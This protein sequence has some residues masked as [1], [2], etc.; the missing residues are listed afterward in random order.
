MI[1]AFGVLLPAGAIVSRY[2]KGSIKGAWLQLHIGLVMTSI[3]FV[4]LALF[5]ISPLKLSVTL[6]LLGTFHGRLGLWIFFGMLLQIA[7]G[8]TAV[9]AHDP[10]AK[11]ESLL[12]KFHGYLGKFLLLVSGGNIAAGIHELQKLDQS[13][14][15]KIYLVLGICVSVLMLVCCG[16]LEIQ[17]GRASR[18]A[19]IAD[20]RYFQGNIFLTAKSLGASVLFSLPPSER[21][22]A[23]KKS[24]AMESK[25]DV[26]IETVYDST[27]RRDRLGNNISFLYRPQ[28]DAGTVK[29]VDIQKVAAAEVFM[30][31]ESVT[32]A[33]PVEMLR[34]LQDMEQ[35]PASRSRACS[36]GTKGSPETTD[37]SAGR[38]R[39]S[40]TARSYPREGQGVS[41]QGSITS[42]TASSQKKPSHLDRLSQRYL[43]G[44]DSFIAIPAASSIGEESPNTPCN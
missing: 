40:S 32:K 15:P 25:D 3:V 28:W 42:S 24:A 18:Q 26:G 11:Q 4:L 43:E 41:R 23:L 38:L 27:E 14:V 21:N 19:C 31:R 39:S 35:L 12:D 2:Y 33:A 36:V 8:V 34:R 44:E 6:D 13:Q 29:P 7:F 16:V 37:P 1:A 30:Q 22:E 10:E 20:A 5:M 9:A 17:R